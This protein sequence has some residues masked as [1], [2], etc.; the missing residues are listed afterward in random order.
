M[1]HRGVEVGGVS[2]YLDAHTKHNAMITAA[3]LAFFAF[4]LSVN[5]LNFCP[6]GKSRKYSYTATIRAR[7][8]TPTAGKRLDSL[9]FG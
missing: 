8:R 7:Q 4:F 3:K 1:H 5:I 2:G 6:G 9:R